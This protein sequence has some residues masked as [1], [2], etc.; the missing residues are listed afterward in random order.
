MIGFLVD[1][2]VLV[3]AYDP[4]DLTKQARAQELLQHLVPRALAVL[5]VQCLT[6]FFRAV[7]WRLPEPLTPEEAILQVTH[8]AQACRVLDITTPVVLAGCR[9]IDTYQ[10]SLWDALIWASA[11]VNQIPCV[12]SEDCEHGRTL[13]GVRY[14]NPFTPDFD[15]SLLETP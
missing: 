12:L 3:Y 1:T 15:L 14:L 5:S 4:R 8:L 11:K 2:N 9:A 6:E 10:M 7:R 13:E